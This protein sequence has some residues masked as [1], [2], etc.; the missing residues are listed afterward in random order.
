MKPPSTWVSHEPYSRGQEQIGVK[1]LCYIGVASG[2]VLWLAAAFAVAQQSP[3]DAMALE[4]L[5]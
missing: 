5:V 2:A 4:Q 3:A 1:K